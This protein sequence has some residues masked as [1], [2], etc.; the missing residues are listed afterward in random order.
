MRDTGHVPLLIALVAIGLAIWAAFG[1]VDGVLFYALIGAVM[2]F[3]RNGDGDRR[4]G[5]S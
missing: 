4:R 3:H 1:F 2:C 5:A